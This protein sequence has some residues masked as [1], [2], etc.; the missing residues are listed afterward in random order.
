MRV[1][2]DISRMHKFSQTRG[3]GIYARNLYASLKKYTNLDVRLIEKEENLE[4]FTLVHFPF[5]DFYTHTLS[6]NFKIPF[7]VTIHDLIPI[8]FSKNY[9]PGVKGRINWEL[10]KHM[11]KKASSII[12]VSESVKGDIINIL[13]VPADKI[14]VIYSAPSEGFKKITDGKLLEGTK[15]KYNLP[16]RFVLYIGNVNWNKNILN[17]TE[18]VLNAGKN[19][20]IIGGAFLDKK[21]LD[22]PEKKSFKEWLQRYD[23]N[24]KIKILDF[25]EEKEIVKIMNLAT[26][27]IFVSFYEGFGLPILEAQA[28]ELPVLTSNNTATKEI[29]GSGAI[30]ANPESITQITDAVNDIFESAQLRER[31]IKQGREN[32]EKFSWK[33]TAIETLKAYNDVLS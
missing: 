30:I 2:I 31:L 32:V 25:V 11:L 19:L 6:G 10:Q 16:D 17:I 18:S 15:Q 29:A 4:G 5:L 7:L 22:H 13:K 20:V 28:S 24:E 33:K 8:I 3:I 12:A 27:L 9:P 21:N 26:C 1:A 14:S 23:G